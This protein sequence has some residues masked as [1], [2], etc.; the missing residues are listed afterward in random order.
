MARKGT[1]K[2]TAKRA[3]KRS[4]AHRHKTSK[5]FRGLFTYVYSPID[6]TLQAADNVTRA[7]TNTIRNIVS[8]G[9][10]GVDRIG[11]RVTTHADAAVSDLLF[12]RKSRKNSRRN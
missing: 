2:R 12:S 4:S 10:T 5:K 7:T 6:H 1:M 3:T 11:R 8:S 9:I